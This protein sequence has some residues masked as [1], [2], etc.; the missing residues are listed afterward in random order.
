[1]RIYIPV[2]FVGLGRAVSSGSLPASG[3]RGYQLPAP[4]DDAETAEY[5]TLRLAADRSLEALRSEPEAPRRRAVVVANVPDG[6]TEPEPD[7]TVVLTRKVPVEKFLAVYADSPDSATAVIQALN[8][9]DSPIGETDLLWFAR[10]E[11]PELVG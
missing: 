1:M 6:W 2:T 10:Q 7:G 5:E 9:K 4:A 3:W 8:G 11:L